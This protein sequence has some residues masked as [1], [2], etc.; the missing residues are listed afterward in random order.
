M[1]ARPAATPPDSALDL[2]ESIEQFCGANGAWYAERFARIQSA[3]RPVWS[4]NWAA[5]LAGPALGRRPRHVGNPLSARHPGAARPRPARPGPVERP[6]RQGACAGGDARA[7]PR[8]H[9][10]QGAEGE[11]RGQDRPR[12]LV[13]EERRQPR[14]RDR[15]GEGEARGGRGRRHPVDLGGS[16]RLAA[17][18]ALRRRLGQSPLRETLLEVASGSAHSGGI[19]RGRAAR[20]PRVHRR[21][22]RRDR[23]PLYRSRAARLRR[24]FSGVEHRLPRSRR[25][26][27][28][29]RLRLGFR[30][31]RGL[32][33][34]HLEGDP[35]GPGRPGN[36]L[37][38]D[39]VA[40]GHDGHRGHRLAPGGAARRH[41]HRR[42]A[43]LPGDS[44]L[45]GEE[46]GDGGPCSAPP[47]SSASRWG[48]RSG[49]GARAA[50]GC[51]RWR[52]RSWTSCRACPRSST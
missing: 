29:R 19:L 27:D 15:Q 8:A 43:R 35:G 7:Q 13:S 20:R 25:V 10:R 37:R 17:R 18:Q 46:H 39:P 45:L 34:G 52:G 49:C 9:A 42:R 16:H 11:R 3:H 51:S 36:D 1:A 40:G 28:R 32:L 21:G 44:R 5:A 22:L 50:T 14:R 23:L 2:R 4:F 38:E 41:L 6:G 47:P 30:E 26:P 33:Q 12:R 48:F 24:G 31:L